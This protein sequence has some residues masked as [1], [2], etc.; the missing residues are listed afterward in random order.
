MTGTILVVDDDSASLSYLDEILQA[1]GHFTHLANTGQVAITTYQ[2][3]A[4][5]LVLLDVILPDMDGFDVCRKLQA[6]NPDINLPVIFMSGLTDTPS[7]VKGFKVGGVDFINKPF[8]AEEVLVR[9]ET[10]LALS[11]SL[12]NT[13]ERNAELVDESKQ[14]EDALRLSEFCFQSSFENTVHGMALVS[15]E[16]RWLKVNQ[17]LCTILGYGQEELLATDFQ[18]I[19]HQD[20]LDNNLVCLRQLLAGK[21][22]HYTLEKR[23]FHKDGHIVWA[24]LNVS[25]VRDWNNLPIY[26]VTQIQD[27]TIQKNAE[28]E[29]VLLNDQLEM[30]AACINRIQRLF[31]EDAR[32]EAVFD[33]L[34]VEILK[35]TSSNHGLIAKIIHDQHGVSHFQTL[36]MSTNAGDH[37]VITGRCFTAMC[38]FYLDPIL[39]G[40]SVIINDPAKNLGNCSTTTGQK[41]S[42]CLGL[43]IKRKNKVVGV[44][45]MANRPQGYDTV[46]LKYLEPVISSCA[47]IIE[48]YRNRKKRIDAEKSLREANIFLI[49][50]SEKLEQI[51]VQMQRQNDRLAESEL[52]YRTLTENLNDLIYRA[53]PLTL[54]ATYVNHAVECVSGY[55][56]E[57]WLADPKIWD[58]LIHQDDRDHVRDC[59]VEAKA[60]QVNASIEYRI[61][62]RDGK[63]RWVVDSF[64]WEKDSV[65][66]I[67]SLTG[68][69]YDITKRK[70]IEQDLA[71]SE[72]HFRTLFESSHDAVM[73]LDK[74]SFFD[75]NASTLALYGY[76][77]REEFCRLHP[78]DVSPSIQPQGEDSLSLA[79]QHI[80][81]ALAQGSNRFEWMHRRNDG[82]NFPAEVLLSTVILNDKT[83]ILAVVRDISERR[84]AE[85]NILLAKNAAEAAN[86]D[87]TTF[88][89]TMSH[90][91]RTPMNGL[92]GMADLILRT[93]LTPKQRHYV[94]TIHRSGRTLLRII[95]DIL[96]LS[97]IQAGRLGVELL[98]FNL[99]EVFHD[100]NDLFLISAKHKGLELRFETE[101]VCQ[102]YLLGDPYRLNQILFNLLSNA[103]KFTE[104]GSVCLS[105]EVLE[106]RE[107]DLLLR[108]SVID[109]G[110]GI[111]TEFQN[112][113]FQAF[114][115]ED[116]SVSRKFGGTGLGLAITQ[117]LVAMMDGELGVESQFGQGSTFWFTAR[118]GKQQ[119]GDRREIAAWEA[120][121]RLPNPDN[122]H[123]KGHILLV[124]DNLVNQEVA[125]ATLELFGC[126]VTVAD[127]GQRALAVVRNAGTAFDAIF[128]DCE[129]PILDGFETT[130]RLRQL[131]NKMGFPHTPIIALTAHVLEES[132]Q[133]C[134]AAGM[135]DYLR[136]PFS[137]TDLGAI[138]YRW[139]PKASRHARTT[140]ATVVSYPGSNP[141]FT[142]GTLQ[143]VS[144]LDDPAHESVTSSVPVLDQL[145]LDR[146][147]TLGRN[148]NRGLFKTM[149]GH[150]LL[151]TPELLVEL[152]QAMARNDPDGVR[153]AAHTLKSS[154]L[155]MGVARLAELGG[156]METN[157]ADLAVVGQYYQ[158]TDSIYSEA[159]QAL[160]DLCVSQQV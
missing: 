25:M 47:Q 68:V 64:S 97:K 8:A 65:G 44:L 61:L 137:Q 13:E 160:N 106:D 11:R 2:T 101:D 114:S 143:S 92:L 73:L 117:K 69:L 30:Q 84:E 154:S 148:G 58:R 99:N 135:D 37:S 124:E 70:Q 74:K 109:T 15:P 146:I 112:R 26:F 95:N 149:V 63:I 14:T 33:A 31:I 83:V 111:A 46:L 43:P 81:T 1:K 104:E 57:E 107:A 100:I 62:H 132:R 32:P 138:L 91:I 126:Q 22:S 6:M 151:R 125:V 127:N 118:F 87:K 51:Q 113:L 96:D 156:A 42:A 120:D 24:L 102:N 71:H 49:R 157:H 80:A 94:E 108:F 134:K 153:I 21:F 115:Q 145:I 23:Y 105:V 98:R 129:M 155:T 10:H 89:A 152:G 121:Q 116:S 66:Q 20:D 76:T 75:C 50:E 4:P 103:I 17:S 53:D 150:Y 67:V 141:D 158:R 90:E 34:L 144:Q 86:Q 56:V 93:S 60:K 110:I 133:Q 40:Q 85:R 48:G 78:A 88:L 77:S 123:F 140:A 128:M 27:I 45:W 52:R 39:G 159:R 16:G 7:K 54:A 3:A 147:M 41:M 139:M 5:D 35:L 119:K 29:L 131:E 38:D 79:N 19:T 55:T 18:T 59:L 142:P 72:A 28:K 9:V 36:A 12:L 130:I 122:I 136:K 82:R